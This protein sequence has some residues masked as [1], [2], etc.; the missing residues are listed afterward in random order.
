MT[1]QWPL[2]PGFTTEVL[3][4]VD[5]SNLGHDPKAKHAPDRRAF[6]PAGGGTGGWYLD[7]AAIA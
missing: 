1:H 2:A 4:D 3:D 6:E 5:Q 7:L